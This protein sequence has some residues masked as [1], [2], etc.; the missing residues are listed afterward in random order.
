MTYRQQIRTEYEYFVFNHI[1]SMYYQV[2]HW[3]GFFGGLLYELSI[4]RDYDRFKKYIKLS[5][6]IYRVDTGFSLF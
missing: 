5:I 1:K 3:M 6:N 4:I 2:W